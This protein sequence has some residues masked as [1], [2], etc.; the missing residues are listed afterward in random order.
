MGKGVAAGGA[1]RKLGKR[2]LAMFFRT[3]KNVQN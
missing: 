3:G 2:L 1:K